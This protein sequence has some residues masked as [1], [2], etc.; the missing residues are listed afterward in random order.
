MNVHSNMM[1]QGKKLAS[2]GMDTTKNLTT[3]GHFRKSKYSPN[4]VVF[5]SL[6]LD[7]VSLQTYNKTCNSIDAMVLIE[8]LIMIRR[9]KVF[10]RCSWPEVYISKSIQFA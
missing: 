9:R 5:R 1:R 4:M 10:S 6:N 2:E 8:N 7:K 3:L